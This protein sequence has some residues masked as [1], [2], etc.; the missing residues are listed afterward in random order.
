M[1]TGRSALLSPGHRLELC[2]TDP[3][4]CS[5]AKFTAIWLPGPQSLDLW[6]LQHK[7]GWNPILALHF[8]GEDCRLPGSSR[9]SA[10]ASAVLLGEGRVLLQPCP[11]GGSGR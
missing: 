2:I 11:S 8:P 7:P 10:R 4:A 9:S 1:A 5:Q 3:E 6:F